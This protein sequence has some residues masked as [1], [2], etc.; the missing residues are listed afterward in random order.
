[1]R[2]L[3][4]STAIR[5]LVCETRLSTDDL[6]QPLFVKERGGAPEPIPSMPGQFR[7][8]LDDLVAEC[9]KICRLGIHG[10]ALFPQVNPERKTEDG[11]EC[12]REGTIVLQAIRAIKK[13]VPELLVFADLALDPY[14]THG[15]DGVL[16][17]EGTDVLNDETVAILS[18]MAVASAKAG[19]DF[20]A[21]SDMMDGRI[22]AIRKALDENGFQ[23]TGIFA[24][25][26]KFNSAYYGPFRDA[27]GS[28]KSAGTTL[29]GKHTY[30]VDPANPSQAIE[31]A[32]LDINEGADMLMVK[33]AGAYLDVIYRLKEK[34]GIPVGAYQVSGEYSQIKAAAQL[35]WLDY[36]RTRD[37]SL[38]AI[39]RA[40]ADLILTYFAGEIAEE[41][42]Q[43]PVLNL[44]EEVE[45]I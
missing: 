22:G 25:S 42:S 21:P 6:I 44:D 1:M 2:R 23:N 36:R 40:G 18:D 16:N 12:V 15:H 30:Q 29:L 8:N 3:R 41:E 19:A 45:G 4:R 33:P 10:V 28:S 38:L 14:T 13:V 37:E 32:L 26:A 39:K 7:Y 9:K 17:D 31:D 43:S 5:S 11:R 35:G 27:V 20:V 34:T 24:Y